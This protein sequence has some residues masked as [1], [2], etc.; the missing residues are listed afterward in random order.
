[1]QV[2]KKMFGA[3]ALIAAFTV[4]GLTSFSNDAQ[5]T[6]VVNKGYEDIYCTSSGCGTVGFDNCASSDPEIQ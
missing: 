5:A 2:L 1:M 4:I 3:T 6:C